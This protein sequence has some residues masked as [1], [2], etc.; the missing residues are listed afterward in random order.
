MIPT[1]IAIPA[2]FSRF[3]DPSFYGGVVI[4]PRPHPR[5]S[6]RWNRV[7]RSRV[8]ILGRLLMRGSCLS[9]TTGP[10]FSSDPKILF[11]YAAA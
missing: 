3:P 1:G 11:Y 4:Q 9:K 8:V 7:G 2:P 6:I 5:H 10:V